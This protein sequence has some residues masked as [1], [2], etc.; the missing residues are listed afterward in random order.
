MRA[1]A[2]AAVLAWATPAAAEPTRILVS[3]G[4]R[5]GLPAERTLRFSENDARHVR[6]VL[7]S[8]GGVRAEH[9]LLLSE[10]NRAA[11]FDAIEKAKAIARREPP[12]DVTLVFY[13][14]GH[15]DRE[16]LHVG[17][18]RVT[19]AELGTKLSEVPAGLRIA[20]TDACRSTRDKGFSADEPFTITT[21]LLA[22][23]SGQ[24]W[25]H[26]SSDGEAAQ[27]S[28][29][30]QGA[31]F[32]HAW[33]SG[34]RGAADMNGDARVTLEESF[35]FAHSQT[36][37]R[38]AKSSGVVQKP[39]AIINLRET[40][41]VVLTRTATRLAAIGLP[42]ARDTHFLV[43]SASAKSVVSEVWSSP[44]RRLRLQLPAGRYVVQRRAGGLGAIATIAVAEGEERPLEDRDFSA[45]TL[46]VLARKGDEDR[47]IEPAAP[48]RHEVEAGYVVGGDGR[49]GLSQGPVVAYA[50][51]TRALAFRVGAG[52]E[53]AGRDVA[54][55]R[56]D[57]TS[58]YGWAG[59][60]LRYP[61]ARFVLHGGLAL[62]AGALSQRID[63]PRESN[64]TFTLGPRL[65][66]GLRT[67]FSGRWFTDLGA[68]SSVVFLREEGSLRGIP[69]L[70]GLLAIGAE[71]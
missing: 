32:T 64:L 31:I 38:S 24:V 2:I 10:P 46:D 36:L 11:L 43:Y 69:L 12:G 68:V 57:L 18:D 51:G 26:A 60:E 58:G 20:V 14:S 37:I 23:A 33:L 52:A 54:G 50:Y 45:A 66:L 7:T 19:L 25:I 55:K 65:D 59:A 34:L 5:T 21:P 49:T 70:G 63:V 56:E 39:E 28:D 61:L 9:A 4:N 22:Q 17:A 1:L 35:A 41:P 15:G 71:L 67:S 13:F 47:P 53:F 6:D 44:V 3:A 48:R 40:A 42:S 16:A 8:L 30:L 62:R 27:E 29:E